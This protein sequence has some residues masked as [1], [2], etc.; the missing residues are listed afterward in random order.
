M[1]ASQKNSCAQSFNR[2]EKIIHRHAKT[3]IENVITSHFFGKTRTDSRKVI[4]LLQRERTQNARATL[5]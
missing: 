1:R 3:R 4:R 5:F 2:L